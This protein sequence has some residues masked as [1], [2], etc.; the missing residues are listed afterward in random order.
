MRRMLSSNSLI[1][2][3]FLLSIVSLRP[4]S[5][6]AEASLRDVTQQVQTKIVKIYG[7]GGLRG[8][9]SYQSGSL[10]SAEGHILTTWSYVLDSSVITAVLDD[11]RHFVAEMLAADPRFG[12]ALLKIDAQTLPHFNLDDG[13]ELRV[14]DR[15]LSFSNLF[16][17]AAGDEPASVLSG[18]V[19]A[20]VPLEARRS[21]FPTAYRGPVVV[22]DAIVN[23]PGAAG[24]VLTDQQ[25]NFAGML[26]RELR[27]SVND[28]WLNYAIPIDQLREP[29]EDMLAGRSRSTTTPQTEKPAAPLTLAHL[30]L[31]LVPDVLDKTPPYVERVEQKS[32]AEAAKLQPD[33]LILY[34]NGTLVAS[35][36]EL[37]ETF[38]YLDRDDVVSLTVLRNGELVEVILNE[39]Q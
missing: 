15:I 33:D 26:G 6:Y 11:G 25:G 31:V 29:V 9:E 32:L 3:L 34:A 1:L 37:V 5:L 19:S 2:A 38:S 13:V 12:I 4:G 21:A 24:G 7:A 36:K 10:I 20:I 18:Y 8:L 22:V 35:Q 28:I 27:S 14:G 39:L 30:G 23:N 17:I 16:G